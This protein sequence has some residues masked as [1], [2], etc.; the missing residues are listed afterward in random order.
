L[1]PGDKSEHPY[2]WL[3]DTQPT[4]FSADG[5]LISFYESGE[6]YSLDHDFQAYYRPTDGS[7]A[8]R[9]GVGT[10]AISPDGK[11]VVLGSN[12]SNPR[13]PLQLQPLGPGQP[14]DLPTPGLVAF[15]TIGWSNDGRRIVYEAQADQGDWSVYTQFVAGSPPVRITRARNSYPALSPDGKTVALREE[16]GGI[17]LYPAD[18]GQPVA[19]KAASDSELPIR[20]ASGGR[21]LLVAELSGRELV[22]TL[23]DVAGG[24][25]QL[26]KRIP[27]ESH[28]LT[29]TFVAT[30]DLKYYAYPFPRYSSVLYTVENLR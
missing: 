9:L 26:W 20:F 14:R 22:L 8:V 12:H 11:W 5:R 28:S 7:P 15:D 4:A 13:R 23:V 29:L 10:T 18:G 16:R 3:D 1:F 25:R 27:A 24:R 2:S 19:L 6:V 21:S 17:S 30:P